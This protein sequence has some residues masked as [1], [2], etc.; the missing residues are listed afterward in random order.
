MRARARTREDDHA[1]G[2]AAQRAHA[3]Q[4]EEE[5]APILNAIRDAFA[6][7]TGAPHAFGAVLD[8]AAGGEHAAGILGNVI[9]SVVLAFLF[10]VMGELVPPMLQ[11]AVN[12]QWSRFQAQPLSPAV[13]ASLVVR[14]FRTMSE[15]TEQAAL[16]GLD[17][18]RFSGLVEATGQ[19]LPVEELLLLWRRGQIST[20]LLEHGIREGNTRDEWIDCVKQLRYAPPSAAQAIAAAVQGHLTYDESKA[21]VS[22]A[23]INPDEWQWLFDTAGRPPGIQQLIGLL[24]RGLVDET[25]VREAILESDIKNKYS[26]AIVATRVKLMPMRTIVSGVR[27]GVIDVAGAIERLQKLG[28]SAEDAALLASEGA[29]G[30]VSHAKHVAAGTVQQAYQDRM[31]DRG[32]AVGM[33]AELGYDATQADFLLDVRDAQRAYA[34]DQ[35][36]VGVVRG[37]FVR[38][39]IESTQA[40]TALDAIGIPG[41]QRDELLTLWAI[42]RDATP[43][44]LPIAELNYA[45]AHSLITP[46]EYSTRVLGMGYDQADAALLLAH[47]GPAQV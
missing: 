16:S 41:S 47:H 7:M 30:T 26:D 32:T 12:D 3:D 39:K 13:L 25:C 18:H 8:E 38:R 14:G 2:I 6:G 36:A 37:A 42:E 45:V 10:S 24:N 19:S 33:L 44:E 15:A 11:D 31:T 21:K 9:Q 28:Y 22:D 46:A 23:G 1:A 20:E 4:L 29:T 35:Q 5:L 27:Q 34:L 17:E 43:R 40:T